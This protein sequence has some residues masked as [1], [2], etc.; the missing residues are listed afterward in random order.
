MQPTLV[1]GL[2]VSAIGAW[3][4]AGFGRDLYLGYA[5]LGW[6]RTTGR[7]VGWGGHAGSLAQGDSSGVLSYEY[8]TQGTI[9]RGNRYDF[10]GRNSGLGAGAVLAEHS[11]G[12][13]I[14]VWFDEE[15]P[16]RAVLAPGVTFWNYIRL[17]FALTMLGAGL[18][19]LA[20]AVKT[21]P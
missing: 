7:V 14:T 8:E 11:L 16:A 1:P 15:Q 18:L 3:L 10:A 2:V 17:L 21:T 12:D 20:N 9:Y 13:D 6:H 4:S 5:S 19:L